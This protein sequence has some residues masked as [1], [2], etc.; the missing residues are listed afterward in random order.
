MLQQSA[1]ASRPA[2]PSWR[3]TRRVPP[4]HQASLHITITDLRS[5]D[6]CVHPL[7]FRILGY[8]F[9]NNPS[10]ANVTDIRKRAQLELPAKEQIIQHHGV[11]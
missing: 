2:T 3:A 6:L 4:P 10:S 8:S 11:T 5:L 1:F 7:D 9:G